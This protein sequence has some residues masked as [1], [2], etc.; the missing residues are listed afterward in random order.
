MR[1]LPG[2][3]L[4]RDN[5]I[6]F[7]SQLLMHLGI[8]LQIML[9]PLYIASLGATAVQIGVVIGGAAI[10][11]TLLVMP[12]GA[13]SD[14]F[15]TRTLILLT[16]SMMVPG[17]AIIAFAQNWW[18][19]LF[20]A[21][22]L[23]IAGVGIPAISSHIAATATTAQRTHAFSMIFSVAAGIGVLVGPP[24]GGIVADLTTLRTVFF[25]V[26][27]LYAGC[28][29]LCLLLT[30]MKPGESSTAQTDSGSDTG[31]AEP[32]NGSY[33]EVIRQPAIVSISALHALVP[34]TLSTGTILLPLFLEDVRNVSISQI[35]LLGAVSAAGGILLGMVAGR[36][37][38]LSRPFSGMIITVI[39]TGFGMLLIRVSDVMI[40]IAIAFFLRG[41]YN[42]VWAM[43]GSA[44]SEVTPERSRG[45]A[46][47][48]AE[49]GAG[50]GDTTA[51]LLAGWLYATREM[52][53]LEVAIIACVPLIG[54][55]LLASW[56]ARRSTTQTEQER[57]QRV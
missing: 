52:L 21:L 18:Q 2:F 10:L 51:P 53:P 16:T 28:L 49:F 32:V 9:W 26:V 39:L 14:R 54:V 29:L 55:M 57:Y 11:R 6:L 25:I 38:H 15:S 40:V 56:L 23:E 4:D 8:G 50:I 3:G 24:I 27:G 7:Y 19:A 17:G 46:Y 34:L 13:L 33:R 43:L 48:L 44:L 45:R 12:A 36:F 42:V 30:E 47:G 22:L 5:L 20:G 31:P 35:G 41:T 1:W 37:R